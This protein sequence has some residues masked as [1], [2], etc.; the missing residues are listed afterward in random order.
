ML[1]CLINQPCNLPFLCIYC[2]VIMYFIYSFSYVSLLLADKSILIILQNLTQVSTSEETSR[3]CL[4]TLL[5][6]NTFRIWY[7]DVTSLVLLQSLNCLISLSCFF[8]CEFLG[9]SNIKV[10]CL[11]VANIYFFLAFTNLSLHASCELVET[12]IGVSK[13]KLV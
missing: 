11:Y 4:F 8:N 7:S 12:F 1:S 10:T 5:F 2:A 3:L 6:Q 9:N 13:Q